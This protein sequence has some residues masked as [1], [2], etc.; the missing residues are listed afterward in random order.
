MGSLGALGVE[1][2]RLGFGT[3]RVPGAGCQPMVESALALVVCPSQ[4][5]A[6]LCPTRERV[7]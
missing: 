5:S 7:L 1:I 6:T 4:R 3:F 2:P